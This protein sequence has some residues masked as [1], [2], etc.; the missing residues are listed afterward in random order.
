[1]DDDDQRPKQRTPAGHEIPVLSRKE[2][3]DDLLK[4][5]HPPASELDDEDSDDG[6]E[7]QGLEHRAPIRPVVVAP[8]VLIDVGLQNLQVGAIPWK[9]YTV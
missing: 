7:Q 3:M 2:V 8:A 5:A 9:R 4:V 6:A 1:M